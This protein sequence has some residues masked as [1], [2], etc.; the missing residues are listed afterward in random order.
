MIEEEHIDK[1]DRAHVWI[2]EKNHTYNGQNLKKSL[3]IKKNV[4]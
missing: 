3:E 1:S 2:E 4:F